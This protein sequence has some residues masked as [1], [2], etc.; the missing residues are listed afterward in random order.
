M[1][2]PLENARDW[3]LTVSRSGGIE[4][5]NERIR[6]VGERAGFA[7]S[8]GGAAAGRAKRCSPPRKSMKGAVPAYELAPGA[9]ADTAKS[10]M[11]HPVRCRV[12]CV[13]RMGRRTR[14]EGGAGRRFPTRQRIVPFASWLSSPV[15]SLI[16]CEI[17][18][19]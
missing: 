11:A 7:E 17:N 9:R 2:L 4:A 6:L 1:V 3:P 5:R 16:Y 13:V 10:A 14:G 18:R 8:L 12:G 15:R 19:Y